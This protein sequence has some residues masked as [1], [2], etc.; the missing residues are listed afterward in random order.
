[1]QNILPHIESPED[2]RKLSKEEL[3]ILAEELRLFI[4]EEVA[5]RGGHLGA[6]LGVVELTVAL[7]YVFNT[8]EDRLVWD[9]G[10]QAYGHKILTGRRDSFKTNRQWQGLSGFP[11][12]EESEYDSFGT[13]HSSTSISAVLGMALASQIKQKDRQHIAV[14]GDASIASGMAFEALNQLGTTKANV[15]VILND[16]GMSI[17]PSVGA[18]HQLFQRKEH[19]RSWFESLGISYFGPQDG[20]DLLGL[21]QQFSQIQIQKGPRLLHLKTIKGKGLPPAE[22]NQVTF[23]APGKF[24]PKTGER[25][26]D[27]KNSL[28]PK[29]QEVFGQT[30]VELGQM[31]PKI[32]AVTPAMPTGSSLDRFM[33]AFPDRSWD[34]G[35]AEQHA[36][37]LSAGMATEGLLPFC[38]IYSTFLQRAYDQ[39]IHDVAL[40]RLPVVFCLDRAG[41]VGQ[42]GATHHGAYDL[43][44]LNCIPHMSI[45][46]PRNGEELR[47]FLYTVQQRDFGPVAIRYPRGRCPDSDWQQE[48]K[49]IPWGKGL[50]TRKGTRKAVFFLGPLGEE[51]KVWLERNDPTQ[52]IGLYDMRFLKP[53]DEALLQEAFEQYEEF[54]TVEDGSVTG[55][56]GSSI[57]QLAQKL[58]M[59]KPIVLKG[60]PDEFIEQGKVDELR[61]QTGLSAEIIGKELLS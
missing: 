58:G 30:L 21:V 19:T 42:D 7:H 9:V 5:L 24:E 54:Y 55:G 36:V 53:L 8:P 35:I 13:G 39:L 45:L 59:A 2:L 51:L 48:F 4:I 29:F 23:H 56:L 15:L 31:N 11:K 10:H 50:C 33:K 52:S 22:L 38:A 16:N 47:Q 40:Q 3:M 34:V 61:I 28:G 60:L 1:M 6:S 32:V 37:T 49:L 14:I 18:L 46:A 43:A 27:N 44:Y 12:R 20:H 57:V 17:D 25:F 26:V 41:L